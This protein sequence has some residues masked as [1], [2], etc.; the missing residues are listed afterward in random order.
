VLA[1]RI[2]AALVRLDRAKGALRDPPQTSLGG[3]GRGVQGFTS[4][5]RGPDAP[6]PGCVAQVVTFCAAVRANRRRL[7]L[8]RTPER[9][10]R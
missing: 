4:S 1:V 3:G 7:A 2:G 9:A 8:W 6:P 5:L 10:N